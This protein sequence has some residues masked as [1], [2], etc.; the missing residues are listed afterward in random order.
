MRKEKKMSNKISVYELSEK[1][2]ILA[3]QPSGRL[4]LSKLIQ[5]VQPSVE[6]SII[7]LDFSNVE[8][9]TSSF[10][11]EAILGFRDY[12]KNANTNLIPV[13]VGANQD[14]LDE[15]SVV[16]EIKGD[17]ILICEL[18]NNGN[19]IN[20]KIL[21]VLEETQ[22]ITLEAVLK[23]RE[24]SAVVLEER[25]R[26]RESIK[27]TGWNNRLTSLAA[28][29]ILIERKKGRKKFYSPVLEFNYGN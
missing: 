19:P 14:T 16:L 5:V 6:P 23:T 13:V 25:F 8:L 4:F 9:M 28:K 26:E 24:T 12:C 11:R 20:A 22:A 3:G 29:G 17:V 21:G 7:F 18:D 10:F 15:F 2:E 27:A 1:K